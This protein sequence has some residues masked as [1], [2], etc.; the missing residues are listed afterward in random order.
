MKP[1]AE[2]ALRL[3]QVPLS[4][5]L[6]GGKVRAAAVTKNAING[7]ELFAGD[8]FLR[9]LF[10]CFAFFLLILRLTVLE[11]G[12]SSCTGGVEA[13]VFLLTFVA[14]VKATSA[15]F[16][17]YASASSVSE[18]VLSGGRAFIVNPELSLIRVDT[19]FAENF[20]VR[21]G[22]CDFGSLIRR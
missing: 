19:I 4:Q 7:V 16:F 15:W 21:F 10:L 20:D 17:P 3:G 8:F 14:V 9:F 18:R 11:S 12:I 2:K 22:E 5:F 13:L 6:P 1:F